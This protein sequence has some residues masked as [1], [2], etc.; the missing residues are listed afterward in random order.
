MSSTFSKNLDIYNAK[1]FKE[2]VSEPVSS[3][4]YFTFGK[5]AAWAND[6]SPSQ[7]NTSDSSF[8][9]VWKNMIGGK[10]VVGNDIRHVVP[11]F[12]WTANTVYYAYD[13]LI[14][15][16]TIA[17]GNNKFYVITDD[18][19]VYKCI[20]N[21]YGANST[22]KPTSLTTT[23]DFQT[24]DGYVWKYMTTL[25]SEERLKFS[26][27]QYIPVK[28]LSYNDG[29]L[30][31]NVQ[32]NATDGAIHSILVTNSGSGYTDNNIS[33]V[34]TGDGVEANAYA[35]RN[36]TSNTISSIVVDT[37]GSGYTFA[38]VT[39]TSANGSNA[40]LR[41]IIS[42]PGGHGSDPLTELGGSQLMISM[43]LI[44]DESGVFIV[45]N[46]FRQ[47]ALIEDPT[48][49]GTSN[50]V[51]NTVFNQLSSFTLNGTSVEYVEDEIV[52]QGNS[53]ANATFRAVVAQWDSPNNIIKV[54]NVEGT[55]INDLLTGYTST[56]ARFL[57]SVTDPDAKPNSGRLLY[58][59]NIVPIERDPDQTESF[60]IVLKF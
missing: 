3:N 57:D 13:N 8:Y 42:P 45:N 59:N 53:L 51:S 2:S 7:A 50:V 44:N 22:V 24:L 19:H 18:W 28:T 26:T 39:I 60:Q 33:I 11:R 56:A 20:A 34:I 1:Q 21:N 36:T 47:I 6:A 52:Y 40:A 31:W 55:P 54:S 9:E 48:Y 16:K 58:L 14:D 43:R 27:S 37:K 38:N 4:V 12:D 30:Q 5:V 41:S 23:T 10:R 35:V 49:Y 46:E 29:T 25:S 32:D 17:N 15:S